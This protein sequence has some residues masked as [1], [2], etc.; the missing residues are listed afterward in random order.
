[1]K[2]AEVLG[3]NQVQ[4]IPVIEYDKKLEKPNVPYDVKVDQELCKSL[5]NTFGMSDE[6]VSKLKIKIGR[7]GY[8]SAGAFSIRNEIFVNIEKP[9]DRWIKRKNKEEDLVKKQERA[10]EAFLHESKHA[11][12]LK[13]I[14]IRIAEILFQYGIIGAGTF[15]LYHFG[16]SSEISKMLNSEIWGKIVSGF[17]DFAVTYSFSYYYNPFEILARRFANRHKDSHE[18]KNILTITPKQK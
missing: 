12:D 15:A 14:K 13:N 17:S 6:Q 11:L 3:G 16:G 10:A 5:L 2:N 1:M 4:A 9:W 8:L 18:W 7:F